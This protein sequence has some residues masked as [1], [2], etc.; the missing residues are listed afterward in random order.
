MCL[1][2]N[3]F[4]LSQTPSPTLIYPNADPT[5]LV[6]HSLLQL[7]AYNQKFMKQWDDP[8]INVK[9]RSSWSIFFQLYFKTNWF[10]EYVKVGTIS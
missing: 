5:T 2:Q 7:T 6:N 9:G 4:P 8:V 10:C 3:R 1:L